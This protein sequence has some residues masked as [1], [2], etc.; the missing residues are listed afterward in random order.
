MSHWQWRTAEC[1][2]R[3]PSGHACLLLPQMIQMCRD[4]ISYPLWASQHPPLLWF[5]LHLIAPGSPAQSVQSS[6]Q[7]VVSAI[8]WNLCSFPKTVTN[9][10]Y[11]LSIT[12]YTLYMCVSLIFDPWIILRGS[13]LRIAFRH[14]L[15][16][17]IRL[18]LIWVPLIDHWFINSVFC[19][20]SRTHHPFP[21]QTSLTEWHCPAPSS[22]DCSSILR[23]Q[24]Q[25][26]PSKMEGPPRPESPWPGLLHPANQ[27]A[28]KLCSLWG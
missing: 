22:Y 5:L 12:D 28:C 19:I 20:E 16:N 8:V 1:R 4:S 23:S 27:T 7:P 17:A 18:P 21:S 24:N 14:V 26:I 9:M 25:L 11:W 3:G 13:T 10:A 15:L 2:K 6:K